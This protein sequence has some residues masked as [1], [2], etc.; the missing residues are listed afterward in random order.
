M[1]AP[2]IKAQLRG[3]KNYVTPDMF[4]TL[5]EGQAM[6]VS[7]E[8]TNPYHYNAIEVFTPDDV[9]FGYVDRRSADIVAPWMD[10]GWLYTCKVIE[11][12]SRTYFPGGFMVDP[13]SVFLRLTPLKPISLR[14]TTPALL[15]ELL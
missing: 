6:I 10:K 13:R 11:G 9:K 7:R 12:P 2:T 8:P 14:K 3:V 4:E 5:T 15:E 1:K